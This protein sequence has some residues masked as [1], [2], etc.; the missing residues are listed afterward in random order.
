MKLF[1]IYSGREMYGYSQ[2]NE[3]GEYGIKLIILV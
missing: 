1:F 2:L 3:K